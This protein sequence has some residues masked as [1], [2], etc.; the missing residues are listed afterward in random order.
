MVENREIE[1]T[2]FALMT[3][4]PKFFEWLSIVSVDRFA[5]C[6]GLM[7]H[8]EYYQC[9]EIKN[10]LFTKLKKKILPKFSS[11]EIKQVPLYL[12]W[13]LNSQ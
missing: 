9:Y 8:T 3:S 11:L 1:S 10:N 2:A 4:N 6:S 7:L 12:K 5:I 13:A